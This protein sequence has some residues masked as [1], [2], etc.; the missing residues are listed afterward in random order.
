MNGNNILLD[1]NIVLYLLG[2]D[3][4]LIPILEGKNLYISFIT[5]LELLSYQGLTE[6]DFKKISD[7]ISQCTVIDITEGIK[8]ITI[9]LRKQYGLKLPDAIIIGTATWFSIPVISADQDF[10]KASEADVIIY[11]N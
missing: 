5:Q 3:K 8:E 9:R 7:F 11:E 10:S 6:K 1:T 2:G 4:T